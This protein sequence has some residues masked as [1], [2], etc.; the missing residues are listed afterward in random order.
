[1]GLCQK[2]L[3]TPLIGHKPHRSGAPMPLLVPCFLART[4]PLLCPG[5]PRGAARASRP[6]RNPFRR[7]RLYRWPTRGGAV[8]DTAI[9]TRSRPQDSTS[10]AAVP[11]WEP[12]KP[13]AAQ[14]SP[15]EMVAP[16]GLKWTVEL[17]GVWPIVG[18]PVSINPYNQS[19]KLIPHKKGPSAKPG[20]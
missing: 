10:T 16:A 20:P 9:L 15:A 14:E 4:R 5:D 7:G 19:R 17:L 8:S 2:T 3:K 12:R 13:W 11:Q 6:R 1:M 18:P